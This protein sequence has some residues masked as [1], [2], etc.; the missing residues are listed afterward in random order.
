[1]W[2]CQC[3]ASIPVE[4]GYPVRCNCGCVDYGDRVQCQPPGGNEN[5]PAAGD[6]LAVY[7][8][9]A[10]IYRGEAVGT[11]DCG[12]AGESAV[13]QCPKHGLCAA[14]KLKSGSVFSITINN[15]TFRQSL[16]F[17]AVCEDYLPT[18]FAGPKVSA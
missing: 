15:S 10:C 4:V 8:S 12:C 5:L 13:Y 1:M 9:P 6:D 7:G 18:P 2:R 16:R 17:C 14:H 3:G 11:W